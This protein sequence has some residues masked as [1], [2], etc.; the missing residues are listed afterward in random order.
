[1]LLQGIHDK[2]WLK[3]QAHEKTTASLQALFSMEKAGHRL[4]AR[5]DPPDLACCLPGA[6]APGGPLASASWQLARTVAFA[7]SKEDEFVSTRSGQIQIHLTRD[8]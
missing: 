7:S 2:E 4:F 5:A 3:R 8:L 1:V 6:D